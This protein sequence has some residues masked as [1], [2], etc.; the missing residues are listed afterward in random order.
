MKK[1]LL[2]EIEDCIAA[3]SKLKEEGAVNFILDSA[4]MISEAYKKGGK[5]LIAGNGGSLCDGM[6]FA[7]EMTGFFRK[8]RRALP[9]IVLSEVG[10]ITCVGNDLGFEHIFARGVEAFGKKEDIFI[11]LSTSG[12][13]QNL[14]N[15]LYVAKKLQLKTISFLGKDGGKSRNLADLEWVVDGFKSSDRIQEAHM[16]AIHLIIQF[17]ER[18]LF[19]EEPFDTLKK[20]LF[21]S[22]GAS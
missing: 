6:H 4:K 13:S 14:I 7:E 10:H 3:V 1:E 20:T 5:L 15:A 18:E 19:K 17:V 16:A 11:S 2:P 21:S 9:A 12:N 8:K 22:V